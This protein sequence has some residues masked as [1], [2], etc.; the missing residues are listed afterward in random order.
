LL[1]FLVECHVQICCQTHL[2][3]EYAMAEMT[4]PK[5]ILDDVMRRWP[6]SSPARTS[7][8]RWLKIVFFTAITPSLAAAVS[9][10]LFLF[11]P[12]S[13]PQWPWWRSVVLLGVI[14]GEVITILW[15]IVG[16]TV[17]VVR[18]L[19]HYERDLLQP[20]I[21]SFNA[22]RNLID[23]LVRT[24]ESRDL[25]YAH[26]SVV[27][28]LEQLRLR[29]G[30]LV[31]ALD[32]VGVIPLGI[33]LYFSVHKWLAEPSLNP[34]EQWYAEVIGVGLVFAYWLGFYSL[35]RSQNLETLCLV[36]KHA[37]QEKTSL[38]SMPMIDAPHPQLTEKLPA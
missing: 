8:Y 26:D 32:K 17:F 12:W 4:M 6:L 10:L 9:I 31:G 30:L 22:E 28:A 15:Y 21:N 34:S 25:E 35:R 18:T 37:V 1:T 16:M 14:A 33:G 5:N 29:I 36:L 2:P 19:F 38:R 24:Y 13:Q 23:Q 20:V 3:G 11:A 7:Q 27:L